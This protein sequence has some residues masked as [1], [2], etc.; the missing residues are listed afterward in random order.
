M[1][2]SR[3]PALPPDQLA[4]WLI[5]ISI[6]FLSVLAA[7]SFIVYAKTG[8]DG[9]GLFLCCVIGLAVLLLLVHGARHEKWHLV[10]RQ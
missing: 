4:G 3:A 2:N 6:I 1:S 7:V 9:L 5:G 10:R 8:P